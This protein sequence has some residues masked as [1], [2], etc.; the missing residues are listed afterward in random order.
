MSCEKVDNKQNFD[1]ETLMQWKNIALILAILLGGCSTTAVETYQ[2]IV[3]DLQ[4]QGLEKFGV[5]H[6]YNTSILVGYK[7]VWAGKTCLDFFTNPVGDNSG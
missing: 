3:T 2:S 5:G 1:L 4:K 7:S 6:G